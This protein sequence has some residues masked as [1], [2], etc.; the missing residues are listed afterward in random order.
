MGDR[1]EITVNKFAVWFYDGGH[2]QWTTISYE[3]KEIA[4]LHHCEIKDL[5]YALARIR[6]EHRAT[7]PQPYKHEA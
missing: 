1:R 4:R 5:E 6:D 7:L 2:P 3:G